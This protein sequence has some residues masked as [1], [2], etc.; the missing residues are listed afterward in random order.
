MPIP[1]KKPHLTFD[2]QIALLKSRG[3]SI[4][5]EAKAKDY[6]QRIGYY[7]L[8]GYWYPFRQTESK[9]SSDGTIV[10]TVIDQFRN[11]AEF[12]NAVD[13]YVF[14]KKL[15]LL[16]LDAL[17]RIEIALRVDVAANLG[18]LDP[19]AHRNPALLHGNFTKKINPRTGQSDYADWLSRFD[20]LAS[21]SKEEFILHY[22]QTYSSPLPIWIAVE[23]WDFGM[24][25]KFL[26][27]MRHDDLA[28]IAARYI[29]PRPELLT[30]W[31]RS[32][33]FVRNTCAHHSR[34]CRAVQFSEHSSKEARASN[35]PRAVS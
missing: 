30:S 10:H 8:S 27:G 32:M 2:A 5:D 15:R 6:L 21:Y 16:F 1:Y 12:K 18:R 17:E 11:N 25:S 9:K 35:P 23:L 4:S 7:R 29:I 3:M 34:L 13:L 22:K 31:M 28:S 19:F 24:L 20:K 33:N 26:S 14:D